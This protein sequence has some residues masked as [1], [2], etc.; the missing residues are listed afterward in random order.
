MD[1]VAPEISSEGVQ[2]LLT[3][4]ESSAAETGNL[5]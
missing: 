1:G 5:S 3:A 2:Q 4:Q